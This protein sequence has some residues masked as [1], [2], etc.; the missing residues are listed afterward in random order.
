MQLPYSDKLDISFLSKLFDKKSECYK[1]F[2][3]EAIMIKVV[4]GKEVVTFNELIN[5]MVASA[6]Y[7]VAEYRL[8]L[9]PRDTLEALVHYVYGISG[10]KSSERKENIILYLENCQDKVVAEKKRTLTKNVPYRLQAPFMDDI[11]GKKEWDVSEKKLADKINKEKRL[12]YYFTLI[13]GLQ[14]KIHVQK[15][16]CQYISENQQILR[17]WIEYNKIM[18]L[19]KRNPSVP[20]IA[21]KLYS[22]QER[23]LIRVKKYWKAVLEISPMKEIYYG[24][25]IQGNSISIDHFVPRSYVAHDE[26]WNLCPTTRSINS[27]KSNNLPDWNKYFPLLCEIEY[28]AYQLVWQYDKLHQIFDKCLDSNVNNEEV[29]KRL[30]MAGLE[31][32]VFYSNLEEIIL[33]VYSAAEKMG[34]RKIELAD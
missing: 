6:W 20:G 30:Y 26:L 10:L 33:P 21:F 1:L 3:F 9:G 32:D 7:M 17:G 23:D 29:R 2:W 24:E 22:N 27:K 18:Y 4:S 14:S 8:N 12:I 11:R 19:Q 13:S 25:E 28:N 16:W 15:E 34:F 31:K 5:E